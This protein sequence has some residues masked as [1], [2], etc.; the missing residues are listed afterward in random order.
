[1]D[2][3]LLRALYALEF[4]VSLI[5]IYT[6]WAQVGGQGHLDQMDWRW[7]LVLGM[8]IAVATVKATGAA[9][10]GERTWNL[11]SLR[12]VSVVIAFCAVAAFITY[13]YHLYEPIE[14]EEGVAEEEQ[15]MIYRMANRQ[16]LHGGPRIHIQFGECAAHPQLAHPTCQSHHQA[17]IVGGSS[18]SGVRGAGHG[19]AQ[20]RQ[21]HLRTRRR[22]THL[23]RSAHRS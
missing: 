15:P 8:G 14:E 4:L 6:V 9:V 20:A 3:R 19:D 1:M 7:K 23:I 13:Y 5:A 11:R 17:A 2:Q 22:P 21:S 16:L 12:W 18:P 10:A